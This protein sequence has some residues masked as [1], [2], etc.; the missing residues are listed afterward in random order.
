MSGNNVELL[1]E[2]FFGIWEQDGWSMGM[3][4]PNLGS[5]WLIEKK[6]L[7]AG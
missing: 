1:I 6:L 7:R 2:A 4:S 3:T 5:S